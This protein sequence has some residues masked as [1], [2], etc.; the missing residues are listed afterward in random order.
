MPDSA[1]AEQ[2]SH[3]LLGPP[4]S[5]VLVH[6]CLI[7]FQTLLLLPKSPQGDQPR[8]RLAKQTIHLHTGHNESLPSHCCSTAGPG[9]SHSICDNHWLCF[10]LRASCWCLQLNRAV[11]LRPG[12]HGLG[13]L[14][15]THNYFTSLWCSPAAVMRTAHRTARQGL[16]ALCLSA[17][18]HIV[19]LRG[20]VHVFSIYF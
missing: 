15:C 1:T 20:G 12:E 6:K 8:K 5:N 19:H 11:I 2:V 4:C 9:A 7:L 14:L 10:S 13:C 16:Q 17:G 18:C 3:P